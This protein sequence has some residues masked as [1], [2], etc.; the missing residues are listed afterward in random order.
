MDMTQRFLLLIVQISHFCQIT[1]YQYNLEFIMN[2][3]QL[4]ACVT[5][6]TYFHGIHLTFEYAKHV[7]V[8]SA[9]ALHGDIGIFQH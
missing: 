7:S 5:L 6:S 4:S 3:M 8:Q 1:I 9:G 2:S